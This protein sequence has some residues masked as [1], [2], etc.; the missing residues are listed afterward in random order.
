MDVRHTKRYVGAMASESDF[1]RLFPVPVGA[2]PPKP[3]TESRFDP[4]LLALDIG[5]AEVECLFEQPSI[6]GCILVCEVT[7]ARDRSDIQSCARWVEM[8]YA[9]CACCWHAASIKMICVSPL[10][11]RPA[12][13]VPAAGG[14]RAQIRC[15]STTPRNTRLRCVY[16]AAE[17]MAE[18]ARIMSLL[19]SCGYRTSLVGAADTADSSASTR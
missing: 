6:N 10:S 14:A 8:D 16:L 17:R 9:C 7:E 4:P 1:G 11:M 12:F 18:G 19:G 2:L 3:T 13:R 15:R 5:M